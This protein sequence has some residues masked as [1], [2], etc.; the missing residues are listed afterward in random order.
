MKKAFFAFIA[1]T[2]ILLLA[3]CNLPF[4]IVPNVSS[5]PTELL[6]SPTTT[7]SPI[8]PTETT[9]PLTEPT[10]TLAPEIPAY[11]ENGLS[12]SLPPCLASGAAVST[13]P[14][15]PFVE[16]G[17]PQEFY[18]EHRLVQ[19]TGYPLVG[20]FHEAQVRI[21]PVSSFVQMYAPLEARVQTLADLIN[22]RPPTP[23]DSIPFLPMF[24]AAQQIRARVSYLDFQNGSGVAF[25]TQYNQYSSPINNYDLFYTYQGLTSDQQYWISAILPAAGNFLQETPTSTEVPQN[26]IPF[27]SDPSDT[28]ALEAYY[29]S[30]ATLMTSVSSSAYTPEITCMDVF[31]Q[32]LKVEN[33]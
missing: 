32:S 33:P 4:K 22:T 24:N 8:L 18:P 5:T 15:V 23:P 11:S 13:V 27:P 12:F 10:A 28:A 16:N 1:G 2:M 31:L 17:G 9:P 7:V 26:G 19:F 14:A 6:P 20:K 29:A 30:A 21:Y 25:L 3:G